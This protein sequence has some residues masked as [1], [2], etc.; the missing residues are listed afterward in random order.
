MA[1]SLK[2]YVHRDGITKVSWD[3]FLRFFA[4]MRR[5][6]IMLKGPHPLSKILSGPKQNLSFPHRTILASFDIDSFK[7]EEKDVLSV[8]VTLAQAIT[9]YDFC[10]L[11][12]ILSSMLA[13]PCT[14]LS[15]SDDCK[16][17]R[18]WTTSRQISL[19]TSIT[20][21]SVSATRAIAAPKPFLYHI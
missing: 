6:T 16:R 10:L 5:S 3:P 19:D 8:W 9:C 15:H 12:I 21:L 13:F 20:L 17:V 11:H 2:T 1:G 7:D 18:Y 4:P 14:T